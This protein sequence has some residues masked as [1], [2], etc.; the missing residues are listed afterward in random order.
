M[1][2][3]K[4]DIDALSIAAIR[5]T[6]IDGI[7]NAKSGHPGVCLSLAPILYT[8][9]KYFVVA[10]PY[11]PYWINRDRVVLSCGHASMLLYTI[12]HL[13]GYNVSIDDLKNFRKFESKTPGHP[14]FGVTEGVDASSG[15]LGQGIAEAVGLALG[16][17]I[18][19]ETYTSRLF[20]HYTYCLCGD[21]CLEE[22]ISQETITFAGLNK[23]SKLILL[24]DKNDV[25][26]D[27]PLAQS[28]VEDAAL[29]FKAANWNVLYVDDGNDVKKIKKAIQKAKEQDDKPTIIIFKT[30]IGYGSKNQGTCKVHGAPLGEDDGNNA[31]LSYYYTYPPFEI[32]GEVY[33]DFKNTFIKR[34]IEKYEKYNQYFEEYISKN[35]ETSKYLKSA[36]NNEYDKIIDSLKFEGEFKSEASRNSSGTFLNFFHENLPTLV[37]GSADVAGS[38]KTHLNNGVTYTPNSKNGTNINWGIR[39]FLMCAASNGILLHGGLRSYVGSFLVFSDYAKSALRMAA[40]MKVPQIYLF[41][42]DSIAVGEDGPTHQPIEHFAMLRSIPNFNMIRPADSR[43]TY[44]AYRV[45][46]K[47]KETPTAIIISRQSLPLLDNSKF[48][49]DFEKGAYIVSKSKKDY[50]D[51][52][53]IATGSEVS[54]AIDAQIELLANGIDVDV[55]SMPSTYLFDKQSSEYINSVLRSPYEKTF[56]IEMASTF[57]WHKYAKHPYGIDRFG[58]SAKDEVLLKKFKFTKEDFTNFILKNLK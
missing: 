34:N 3:N 19:S 20:K 24:Y 32:P 22:G 27:G 16:E 30:I 23:L 6:A 46:L 33:E 56:S 48:D 57:G 17:S 37:G 36:I 31:K 52:T 40:L 9:Y 5:A 55:V 50:P 54:L 7:N 8:L 28:N 38:V 35:P 21:G 29:R 25:T 11:K 1:I 4:M 15:P 45:A 10:N 58:A 47:S 44:G 2:N 41:S 39:E 13:C 12:L 42:H 43:E 49:G 14:E 26:L 53:I 51:A 18:L